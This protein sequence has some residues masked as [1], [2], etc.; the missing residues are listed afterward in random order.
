METY[1]TKPKE[2]AV[3]VEIDGERYSVA[4][5]SH[6]GSRGW[7]YHLRNEHGTISR[8]CH[9]PSYKVIAVYTSGEKILYFYA[10]D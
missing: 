1:D 10:D 7:E 8:V 5:L 9:A 2:V 6:T 3:A 4:R